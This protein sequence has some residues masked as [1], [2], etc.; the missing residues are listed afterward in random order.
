MIHNTHLVHTRQNPRGLFIDR[1][2]TLLARPSRGFAKRMSEVEFL[3]GAM[4]A[5]YRAVQLGWN[6]YLIGNEE[7]VAFGAQTEAAWRKLETGICEALAAHG[8]PVTRSYSCLDHPKGQK[9]YDQPSV[10]R[11]PETGV[12]YHAAHNDDVD[13]SKSWVIGDSTI[14]LAAAWRGDLRTI[15]VR[16]G[17]AI[18]DGT[19]Q[20]EPELVVADL[21]A[22]IDALARAQ[23]EAA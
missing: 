11:L 7:A 22:A 3:P 20:V 2:G 15:G 4:D 12:F 9:G 23:A 8:A 17:E 21:A 14:E 16:T 13:L 19:L 5:L 1:W 6:V 18:L 10:F